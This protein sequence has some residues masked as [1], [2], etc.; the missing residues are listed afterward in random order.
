M[1]KTHELACFFRIWKTST[2]WC[3]D[4]KRRMAALPL[5][6]QAQIRHIARK[7]ISRRE[8]D[9]FS[10]LDSLSSPSSQPKAEERMALWACLWQLIWVYRDITATCGLRSACSE[11]GQS[12]IQ[13][14]KSIQPYCKAFG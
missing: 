12:D 9:I 13:A 3:E 5:S 6:V 10:I 8:R 4:P 11:Q 7:A 14:G 1:K 2:F